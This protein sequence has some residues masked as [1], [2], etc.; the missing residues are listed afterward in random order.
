MEKLVQPIHSSSYSALV[1]IQYILTLM[2]LLILGVAANT[3]ARLSFV[4]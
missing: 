2:Q 4:Q 1:Y 3:T